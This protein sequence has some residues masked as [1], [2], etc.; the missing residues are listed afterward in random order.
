MA[1]HLTAAELDYM[2]NLH[3]KCKNPVEIHESKG[4]PRYA[5]QT[6]CGR[7]VHQKYIDNGAVAVRHIGEGIARTRK[8]YKT[9]RCISIVASLHTCRV[10]VCKNWGLRCLARLAG[11]R[12]FKRL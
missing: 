2:K 6:W 9:C 8:I 12:W 4:L 11:G 1:P 3:E 5:G 7:H 10:R